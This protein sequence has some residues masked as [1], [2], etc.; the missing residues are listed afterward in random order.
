MEI[1]TSRL[2]L[3]K[4][5]SPL[6]GINKRSFVAQAVKFIQSVKSEETELSPHF[7]TNDH[8]LGQ[9]VSYLLGGGN[10]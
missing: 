5:I 8:T 2:S 6:S 7:I 4:C 1:H 9:S 10:K 3:Y